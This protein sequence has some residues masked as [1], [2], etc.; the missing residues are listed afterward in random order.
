MKNK[1]GEGSFG[2]VYVAVKKS[3]NQTV[4]LKVVSK[5]R[6]LNEKIRLK[7]V[8]TEKEVMMKAN[9]PFI[10][11]L[12]F[13]FQ[14]EKNLYYGMQLMKGGN[15]GLYM[16]KMKRFSEETAQFYCAQ[17]LLALQYLRNEL[18]TIYWDL[19]P[20]NILIDEMGYAKLTDFGLSTLGTENA[21]SICGTMNYIAPEV[22]YGQDYSYEVDYWS[23][24]CLVFEMI[25][26][27]PPFRA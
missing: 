2:K 19:K 8:F 18:N 17:I 4:A 9:H 24:G 15:L 27:N 11:P 13:T 20:E 6:L 1:I 23:L 26:G 22:L 14:D 21:R 16:K 10:V 12:Y 3:N 25:S 5:E 7:D